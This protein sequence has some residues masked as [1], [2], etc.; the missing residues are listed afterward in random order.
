MVAMSSPDGSPGDPF[1]IDEGPAAAATAVASNGEY[2]LV[3]FARP[4]TQGASSIH[5]RFL[6]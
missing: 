3:V 4:E 6:D 2:F 5:G 1:L